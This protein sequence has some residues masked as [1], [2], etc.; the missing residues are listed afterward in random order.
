MKK[1]LVWLLVCALLASLVPALVVAEEA[2]A[3]VVLHVYYQSSRAMN[4]HTEKIRQWY[5]DNLNVD[6]QLTQ[7]S[8]NYK[9][10]LALMIS[11]GEIPD[12]VLLDY[13][14]Y[15][16]YAQEGAFKDIT[17]DVAN[18]PDLMAY[19][20]DQQFWEALKV[21]GNIYGVPS[22]LNVPTSHVTNIRKDWLDK[23]GLEVPVT[24]EDYTNVLRA[25]T[26][27]DPDGNGQN[28]TFGF[29]CYGFD[30]LS[31]FLGAFDATGA[32]FY[33]LNDDGT[34]TTNA[35]SDN[36]RN[37]L[38]YLR[39]LYA[40]GLLDPELFTATYEQAQQKWGRGQM[41]V[42]TSWWSGAGNAV[43]RFG[44]MD[45]QPNAEQKVIMPPVGAEGQ[46]GS[47]YSPEFSS[48]VA[49]GY[50]VSQ[51]KVDAA[52]RLLNCQST[53]YGFYVTQY[54]LE[55]VGFELDPETQTI[56]WTYQVDGKDKLGNEITDM[57]VYKMLFQERIQRNTHQVLEGLQ[58]SLYW[59]ASVVQFATPAKQNLFAYT[60]TEEYL[61][62]NSELLKY[63]T[64][65]AIRFIMGEK[66]IE[67][68]WDRYVAEYLSMG[69]EAVR[70]SLLAAYNEKM[71][72]NYT[73]AQ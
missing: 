41:G 55:G 29:S 16:Q 20:G 21:D 58:N 37:G 65:N 32:Q 57:E 14:T 31:Q 10:Q 28:D 67:T 59:D 33:F 44:F 62:N 12:L 17:K 7:A 56:A 19:V 18:Y 73:F 26:Q 34:I 42:W 52:L 63:F 38:R 50:G 72:T 3:P 66:D 30:F 23:L 6:V 4:E 70:D 45:L 39:G 60:R 40:E 35:I 11:S 1:S 69:G 68:D 46:Q 15:L 8:D 2:E 48:V 5:I 25:F 49:M 71:G 47:L 27:Q 53:P 64:E 9:Q 61:L 24:L 36:Y 43:L 22:M 51:E 13:D 54:G